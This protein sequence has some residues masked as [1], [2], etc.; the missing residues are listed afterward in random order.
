MEPN[1]NITQRPPSITYKRNIIIITEYNTFET[2][3]FGIKCT[4]SLTDILYHIERLEKM[5]QTLDSK[6]QIG[7]KN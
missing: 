6:Y 5:I 4:G 2:T 3:S 1:S 7:I